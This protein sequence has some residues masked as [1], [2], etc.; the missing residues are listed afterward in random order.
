M[1]VSRL[2]SL[3]FSIVCLMMNTL[4][5]HD[6]PI[7]KPFCSSSNIVSDIVLK[8]RVIILAY[9]LKP[10]FKRLITL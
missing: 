2:N 6:L 9:I 5:I 10:L 8:R 7:L 1:C 3:L 4:S